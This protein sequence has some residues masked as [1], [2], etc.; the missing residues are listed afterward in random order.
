M[1]ELGGIGKGLLN[2][3]RSA[4]DKAEDAVRRRREDDD[5][6]DGPEELGDTEVPG[7]T[8]VALDDEPAEEAD[9]S[10]VAEL[11]EALRSLVDSR[12]PPAG[13]IVERWS[14][15]VGD[16]LAE[17]PKVPRRLRGLV[18]KLDRFGGLEITPDKIAFDGDDVDW[19]DVTEIRTRHV[20][21]YLLGDAVQAQVE[22]LPLPWFPGRRRLLDALGKAVLTVTIAT[23]KDQLEHRSLDLRVPAEIEYRGAFRRRK[24]LS[25]GVIAAVLLADPAVNRCLVA[26]AEAK[27]IPVRAAAD[28]DLADAETR[29]ARLREQVAALEHELDRFSQR[30]GKKAD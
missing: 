22:R 24:E 29:A 2:K 20:V 28:E 7:G 14:L 12:R 30:F 10:E 1:P 8:E 23:A 15:G 13:P 11:V 18:R 5:T 21:D 27:G 25:A 9:E 6:P 19:S 4:K 26:T 16:L 3:A 17:Q